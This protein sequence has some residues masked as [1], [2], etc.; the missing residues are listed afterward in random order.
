VIRLSSGV[1]LEVEAVAPDSP[2]VPFLVLAHP[3]PQM[4]GEMRHKIIDTLFRRSCERGWG[5]VRLNFRGVGRSTGSYDQG[6]GETDDL[7]SILRFASEEFSRSLPSLSLVGYSFGAWIA[8]RVAQE[9]PTLGR[10]TLIAPPVGLYDFP[11]LRSDRTQKGL[12]VADTDALVPLPPV[13]SWFGEISSPKRIHHF[14]KA[15]HGFTGEVVRLA[16]AV[17]GEIEP[18]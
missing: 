5:A 7:R 14:E 12:F 9:M 11:I 17:L 3:H 4:G 1:E 8:A 15:D 6:E 16:R 10:V 13:V 18:E 2:S